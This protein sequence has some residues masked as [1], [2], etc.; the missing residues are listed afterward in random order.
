MKSRIISFAFFAYVLI[1]LL[2]I[3]FPM[4]ANAGS[5]S[6]NV[7]VDLRDGSTIMGTMDPAGIRIKSD[8]IGNAELPMESVS[9]ITAQGDGN[10]VSIH[11]ENG[12][13]I[14]GSI[15]RA[16]FN[17]KTVFG[18]VAIPLK[19]IEKISISS[20]SFTGGLVAY[21]PFNGN[22][23]DASGNGRNGTV[24]GAALV[25]DQNGKPNHAYSFNGIDNYI[26]F[27]R[28]LPDMSE[29]TVST[30]AY[31]EKGGN[32]LFSDADWVPGSDIQLTLKPDNVVGVRGDKGGYP[33][34]DEV[35]V[36]PDL[37]N[38]WHHIAWT[39]SATASFIYIDG[40]LA[41]KINKGGSNVNYHDFVLGTLEF[42]QGVLGFGGYW[43]G[44]LSDFRIYNRILSAS[45]IQSLYTLTHKS[46]AR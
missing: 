36:K 46:P 18:D 33:L 11:Y 9:G 28:V 40:L 42:P 45:E 17:I 4:N 25:A 13:R 20:A 6:L 27:G 12:D 37:S 35:K 39:M 38:S 43:S 3:Q 31:L 14:S 26:Y 19:L 34:M 21:Y 8:S 23:N 7:K 44:K 24:H 5:A 10:K 41:A 2:L 15:D 32:T 1:P 16:T 30:W 22:A 29:M